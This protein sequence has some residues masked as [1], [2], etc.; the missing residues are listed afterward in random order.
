VWAVEDCRHAG[1]SQV[2]ASGVEG[3]RLTRNVAAGIKLPKVQRTEMHFLDAEQVEALAEV[4]DPRYGTLIRFASYSGLRPSE[5]TAL[6]VGRLDLL[7]GTARVV[8]AAPEVD[9]HLHWSG[10]KTHEA[11]MVRCAR[12]RGSR[13]SSSLRSA[14]PVCPRTCGCTTF[15]I[16]VRRC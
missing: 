7:R 9:G 3:G 12:I 4:I 15:G 14:R 16:P 13:A 5:L 10:I 6:R 1:L 2:L 11:R 8:E